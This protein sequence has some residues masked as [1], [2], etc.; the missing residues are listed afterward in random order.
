ML[1][2]AIRNVFS[3]QSLDLSALPED[4]DKR[5]VPLAEELLETLKKSICDT[6]KLLVLLVFTGK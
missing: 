1:L 4:I 6:I 3:H 5:F 2:I